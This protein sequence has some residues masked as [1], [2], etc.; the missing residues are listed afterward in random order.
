[1]LLSACSIGLVAN[2]IEL[3]SIDL[4]ET[5]AKAK[6]DYAGL[7]SSLVIPTSL[8]ANV[9]LD[10]EEYEYGEEV[11]INLNIVNGTK[12][13][14]DTFSV[15]NK[16][17]HKSLTV[18]SKTDLRQTVL[19]AGESCTKTLSAQRVTTL[20]AS[21]AL[22]QVEN[23][24]EEIFIMLFKIVSM[25]PGSRIVCASDLVYFTY[26][27]IPTYM[28]TY[29]FA[30]VSDLDKENSDIPDKSDV[31]A[32]NDDV[33]AYDEDVDMYKVN[34][35]VISGTANAK[36]VTDVKFE[37]TDDKNI[38]ISK[39]DAVLDNGE[40]LFENFS[41]RDGK[42]I[43][44]VFACNGNEIAD[45][46]SVNLYSSAFVN[47]EYSIIDMKAD[48]DDDGLID[49]IEYYYGSDP[50]LDD[51][52]G[53]GLSDYYEVY[54]LGYDSKSDD[55]DNN[56]VLDINE[57]ADGDGLSNIEE[58]NN[59]TNPAYYDTDHD[60]VSDYDEINIHGTDPLEADTDKD[61]VADGVEI[62]NGSNPLIAETSFSQ[63]VV[64]ASVSK[65]TPVTAGAVVSTD[66]AGTGSLTVEEIDSGENPFIS[67]NI[68][69]YI[70][71]A[72]EFKVNGVLEK[73]TITFEYDT[74][75]GEIG[76][77]FQPR[78]YW[79]N[80]ETGEF[81]ELENQTVENGKVSAIVEHFSTYILLNKVMYDEVWDTDIKAP[82]EEESGFENL[83]ISFV[84]DSS[85]SM[86]S[87]DRS[88][89]RKELTKSFID[90]MADED[91]ASIID[92]DSYSTTYSNFTNDKEVLKKAV[93][94][95]DSSGGTNMYNGL[96]QSFDLFKSLD[97]TDND[98]L[99]IMFLLTDGSDD[100]SGGYYS[101][102]QYMDLI[103]DCV[104]N[105]IQVYTIGLG[106]GVNAQLLEKLALRGNGKYYFAE[107]DLNLI[108]G[109]DELRQETIDYITD[110][111][112]DGISDYYTN[113]IDE[114]SLALSN[115]STELYGVLSVYGAD[116]A[117][118]DGDGLKNGE[119][120]QVINGS[121]G[122]MLKMKSN[123][124][125]S[126]SDFDGYNDYEEVQ[127]MKTNPL[128]K[129]YDGGSKLDGLLDDGQSN[130]SRVGDHSWF[131]EI[132]LGV[133]WDRKED[134]KNKLADFFYKYASEESIK[135]NADAIKKAENLSSIFDTLE[136][137]TSLAK[138]GKNVA[139]IAVKYEV[140]TDSAE[141]K[142]SVQDI[143]TQRG[144]AVE[145][146][147]NANETNMEKL[148]K[149]SDDIL[150]VIT[151]WD[152]YF[153]ELND[154]IE[155][156]KSSISGDSINYDSIIS[157]INS[158]AK[159]VNSALSAVK[160]AVGFFKLWKEG[161][162]TIG[163]SLEKVS[164][165]AAKMSAKDAFSLT[166]G[167]FISVGFAVVDYANEVMD[168][169]ATYSKVQA[170]S[171]AFTDYFDLLFYISSSNSND[172]VR[173]SAG[174]ILTLA[175]NNSS[176][177]WSQLAQA[178]A[179]QYVED[180]ISMAID[181]GLSAIS[182]SNP[183]IAVL[184]TVLDIVV[185]EMHSTLKTEIEATTVA[186]ITDACKH[187][188][189][190]CS[191]VTSNGIWYEVSDETMFQHYL[192]H[193]V[194]GRID[195]ENLIYKYCD[196]IGLLSKSIEGWRI[197]F[198]GHNRVQ[199]TKDDCKYKIQQT[200]RRANYL[201]VKYSK[202]LPFY[203]EYHTLTF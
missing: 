140:N 47:A 120:I 148:A 31:L 135:A 85:G 48:G 177:Y 160:N 72:Y 87:S 79:L 158:D 131:Q 55:T 112:N 154:N 153:D 128:I 11:K 50:S 54:Y 109:F 144:F 146:S 127:N 196:E 94:K 68:S 69:G 29:V 25:L 174:E 145:A 126:D 59:G 66:A 186:A 199:E 40:W 83:L 150:G 30:F 65:F 193:L 152:D 21:S 182:K 179:V 151:S 203:S 178:A 162:K 137:L 16:L 18:G 51:T 138:L 163:K 61:G 23:L 122:P 86:S 76:E 118:W 35:T 14:L 6:S 119:E 194:H 12:K 91:M 26:A 147:K 36:T 19:A 101:E 90:K 75:I 92:F 73:A 167:D 43:L 62:E 20:I 27:G 46:I 149:K 67:S 82:N 41:L 124:I 191:S 107:R 32:I 175:L 5:A 117:D 129:T 57:D 132:T 185:G 88:G 155:D 49:Y 139:D 188:L 171:E 169:A 80:E 198:T 115:G 58:Q 143:E 157:E 170:N 44:T 2:A 202:E 89:L 95:I 108:E 56:G 106:S 183:V 45:S 189:L 133:Y 159:L 116:S 111:N 176:E 102:T 81:E 8:E 84:I 70:G 105:G 110:S 39:G 134:S 42:N 64:P 103:D 9:S 164:S 184:K 74:S 156:K 197:I 53:D 38:L 123:P 52:D 165:Y 114:G 10:K 63:S 60:F 195:G 200:Y 1:M 187:Y 96:S 192:L 130:A 98:S 104:A 22:Y 93:K 24:I 190:T 113:L 125:N 99:K 37:I 77:Y 136:M 15:R 4:E 7:I 180:F 97:E 181:L 34:G 201:G 121:R 3:P 100:G 17:S 161:S 166:T 142:K 13:Q 28:H 141:F 71:S 33:L 173:D 78:I 168:M 172:Y